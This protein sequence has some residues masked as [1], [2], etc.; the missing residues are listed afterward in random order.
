MHKARK[1]AWSLQLS[2]QHVFD[3]KQF[4]LPAH[5][6]SAQARS[7]PRPQPASFGR[8][9]AAW[10]GCT[11]ICAGHRPRHWWPGFAQLLRFAQIQTPSVP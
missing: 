2:E 10:A 11:R 5:H 1:R 9:G 8:R 6:S 4:Y 7:A 3:M